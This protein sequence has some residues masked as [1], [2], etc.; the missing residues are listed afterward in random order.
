[1]TRARGELPE[2]EEEL[3]GIERPTPEQEA[4]A[5]RELDEQLELR[6]L[7]LITQMQNPMFREWLRGIL[8]QLGAFENSFGAT[9][10]GFPDPLATQFKLGMKAGGWIL[11]EMFDNAAPELTALMRREGVKQP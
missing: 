5:Q 11:W 8:N 7:F 4:D 1:M 3:L 9:P 10:V 2:P 6:R